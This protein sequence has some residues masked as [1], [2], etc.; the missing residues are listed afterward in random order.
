MDEG[1]SRA[2]IRCPSRVDRGDLA[3]HRLTAEEHALCRARVGVGSLCLRDEFARDPPFRG[4]SSQ[5]AGKRHARVGGIDGLRRRGR[6][7]SLDRVQQTGQVRRMEHV[8]GREFLMCCRSDGPLREGRGRR[9]GQQQSNGGQSNGRRQ[10]FG[11]CSDNRHRWH[12]HWDR[13][14]K[15]RGVPARE[16]SLIHRANC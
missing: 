4:Q 7:A 16:E 14:R 13:H 8:H 6:P 1:Q 9:S 11:Q 15:G 12:V 10:G 2:R 5:I 3:R